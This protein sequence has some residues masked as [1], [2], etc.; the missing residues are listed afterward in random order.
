MA[1]IRINKKTY[2]YKLLFFFIVLVESN[3]FGLITLPSVV[4]FIVYQNRAKWIAPVAVIV[5]LVCWNNHKNKELKMYASFLKKYLTIVTVSIMILFLDAII[6]YPLNE[7]VTTYGFGTYYFYAYL[8]IPLVYIFEIE[9]FEG[10]LN[11]LTNVVIVIYL[12]TIINGLFFYRSGTLLFQNIGDT[13]WIRDGKIRISTGAFGG[14][15]LVFSTY[16]LYN[17]KTKRGKL[18]DIFLL[19]LGVIYTIVIGQSRVFLLAL[20]CSILVLIFMGDGKRNKKIV[21]G[22][23][24]VAGV[25][26]LAY[27]KSISTLFASF[28]T[29]GNYGGSTIARLS[30]WEYYIKEFLKNP[31]TA[32][33]FAGDENYFSLV[34]GDSGIYY[35]TV[36]VNYYYEDCGFI[37]LLAKTGIF[38]FPIY[39]WPL[40]RYIKM[41]LHY[42]KQKLIV[43]GALIISLTAYLVITTPTLDI[44]SLNKVIAWPL[45]IAVCEFTWKKYRTEVRS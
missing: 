29:E 13:D 42:L 7:L 22:G 27:S 18:K 5:G 32:I 37:G 8:A 2:P 45:I 4:N 11:G 10:I 39:M 34:H 44:F 35:Q 3:F 15:M 36:K 23:V 38:S 31:I 25:M 40:F 19:I 33:G 14:I 6:R 9:G 28:S 17:A 21:F 30:A 41:S 12:V 26:F 20:G 16:R 24:V 43:P 1:M